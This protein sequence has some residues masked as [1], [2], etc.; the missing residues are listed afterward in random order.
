MI[1]P[2]F[3]PLCR[4][5]MDALGWDAL[6]VLCITGDAYVDHPAFGAALIGR[7]LCKHGVRVG[8][9]AQPRWDRLDDMRALGTP[10]LFVGVTAGSLDSLLAHYTAF[11]K[12]RGDDAYTPGGRAG[13][14][15]NRACTVYA[16]L[17]RQAFPGVPVV[18][19]G[20]EASLRR[21]SHYD[22]WTDAVRR[23]LLPDTKADLLVYGM[24]E[25]AVVE[26]AQRLDRGQP[27][28]HIPGTAWMGQQKDIPDTMSCLTMPSHETI[29]RE[30]ARLL[31][32]TRLLE[33]HVHRGHAYAIQAVGDRNVI[34]A[35]P[36][37][38][39]TTAQMDALYALP[40]AR[41]QHP[42][43]REAIPAA[44][45]LCHSITSHRGCGGG[46]SFCALALHQGRRIASRSRQSIFDEIRT[47][48]RTKDFTGAVS[49]IG[50][51]TANMWQARC[52]LVGH[53]RRD[54][55]CYPTICK[56]FVTAQQAHVDMLRA[57]RAL[58][59]VK[60][61]RV[62]SGLRPDIMG[63]DADILHAYAVEFAGG[64][65]KVAP[66]HCVPEVLALMRKPPAEVFERFVAAFYGA[67]RTAGRDQYVVPYLMSAFPGC[68][69]A[70]MQTLVRWL[71]ARRWKPQQVQCF[72]PTPGTLATALYYAGVDAQ[73]KPLNVARNDADRLRQHRILLPTWGRKK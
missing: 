48:T 31:H 22:F 44:E 56:H 58:P 63:E 71:K 28:T 4:A 11:R 20:I 2:G 10:R 29:V 49:D 61:V 30:P 45:M 8:I 37:A 69:E 23:S 7:W 36:A 46:C 1:Q 12:K 55:C 9:V 73:G 26:I 6:D 68:T 51:P 34:L 43:Y 52:T 15:P 18:L 14:R 59:G 19:G 16:N 72:V 33:E 60:H 47:M 39:L 27:I 66:E 3:L 64:Q 65:C 13:A 32:A 57:A 21:V 17:A 25:R 24:G 35:P 5:E 38:P 70:S 41:A 40:F 67:N 50:G 54:S 62:A 42:S 53:C